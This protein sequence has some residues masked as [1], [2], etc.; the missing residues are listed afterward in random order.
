VEPKVLC[1]G[2]DGLVV[3]RP[4]RCFLDDPKIKDALEVISGGARLSEL[5]EV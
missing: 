4:F 3:E 1:N 5:V 2:L